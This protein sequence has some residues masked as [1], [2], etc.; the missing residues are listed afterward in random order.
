MEANKII[1][2]AGWLIG[3]KIIQSVIS[4]VV[5]MLTARF[6][7]PSNFG[8]INYAAS[9]VAFV[10]PIMYLGFNG[11]LVKEIVAA[12]EKEGEILGTSITLSFISG[13]ICIA[14]VISFAC[15]VNAGETVTI[16]VCALY[17][18][19]LI[20]QSLE[21]ISYWFQAKLL[22]KYYSIVSFVAYSIVAVYKVFLLV[23]QKSVYWFAISNALDYMLISAMLFV[24]YKKKSGYKLKFSKEVAK[25]MFAESKYYI[26]SDMMVAIF[27]QT[28]KIM[29]KLMIDD[30]ATGF[31][32]AAVACS[33]ITMF[34][35]T[36]IIDS[37]RPSVFENKASD[38]N[39]YKQSVTVLY[40]I[41]IYLS[42]IQ[43][44]F[45]TVFSGV[46]IRI[47]Y[48]DGY[49]SS[50]PALRIVVWYTTFS[51]IGGIRNIW[52]LA[53][54]KQKYMLFINIFGALLNV[55]L[56]FVL[57]PV[58]QINGAAIASLATQFFANVILGFIIKPIRDNNKLMIKALNP[59]ILIN[60]MRSFKKNNS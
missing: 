16:V 9:I 52:L 40:S 20:F 12:P 51:Y 44:V 23:T 34:I 50:I 32:S 47:L 26:L 60:G 22:S 19:L 29:L 10:A 18:I 5:S 58:L 48:G 46:I 6:L 49:A 14:G 4:L 21:L 13:I 45:I 53:E 1:K 54:K 36:A 38:E 56:N 25:A 41:I 8:L 7:G 27:A 24:I 31:Y 37:M 42:L 33:S 43:S 15:I 2:N 3:A 30:S 55:V 28:D 35:F 39:K 11:I 17:S 57:I 59:M